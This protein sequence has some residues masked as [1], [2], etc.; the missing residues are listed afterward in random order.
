[1]RLFTLITIFNLIQPSSKQSIC[2]DFGKQNNVLP[3]VFYVR[4]LIFA[5]SH[6][7]IF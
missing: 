4:T 1:M 3:I 6:G 2:F 7:K 5:F